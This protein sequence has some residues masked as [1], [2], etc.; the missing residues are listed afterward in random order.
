LNAGG[1]REDIRTCEDWELWFRLIRRGGFEVVAQ[2]VTDYYVY[3]GSNS[4]DP[5]RMLAAMEKII[6]TTLVADL[7]G[8]RRRI[9]THRIRAVQLF[10]AALI[11]R[12]NGLPDEISYLLRSIAAWPSPFCDP[13]RFAALAVSLRNRLLGRR[14][15]E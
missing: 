7:S 1:F 14:R 9:W 8:P 4:T 13:R 11:A 6:P 2:P 5:R 15:K 3:T 10:S 12:E